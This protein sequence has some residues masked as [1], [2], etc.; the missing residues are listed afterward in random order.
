MNQKNHNMTKWQ[1]IDIN[2]N[3][4]QMLTL[5]GKDYRA[6]FI[7]MFLMSNYKDF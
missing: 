4:I 6:A 7:G 2:K 5:F 3:K 1:S